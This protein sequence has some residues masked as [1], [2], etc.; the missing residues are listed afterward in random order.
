MV[1]SSSMIR[2]AVPVVS[3]TARYFSSEARSAS[4]I[5][6]ASVTS[7]N[8]P[9]RESGVPSLSRMRLAVSWTNM[10]APSLRLPVSSPVQ[11]PFSRTA[12]MTAFASSGCSQSLTA[13]LPI[14]FSGPASRHR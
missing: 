3:K 1:A 11:W 9:M 10:V 7:T 13:A 4:S 8:V 14:T 2:V 6:L 12:A 5:R